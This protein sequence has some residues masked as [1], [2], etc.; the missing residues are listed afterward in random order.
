[1]D[2]LVTRL[3]PFAAM[4]RTSTVGMAALLCLVPVALKAQS[5]T[6]SN[7]TYTGYSGSTTASGATVSNM[8]GTTY[9]V[10]NYTAAQENNL[11]PAQVFT[12]NTPDT[13]AMETGQSYYLTQTG[14]FNP[15]FNTATSG[16][17]SYGAVAT[18]DTI[19]NFLNPTSSTAPPGVTAA[20]YNTP[21]NFTGANGTDVTAPL[22]IQ[23]L[24][25]LTVTQADTTVSFKINHDEAFTLAIGNQTVAASGYATTSP[26]N[27][28]FENAGTYAFTLELVNTDG[29]GILDTTFTAETGTVSIATTSGGGSDLLMPA[30][31]PEPSTTAAML[32]ALGALGWLGGRKRLPAA[33]RVTAD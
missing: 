6:I 23:L 33:V 29:I 4:K 10:T 21:F 12:N 16:E 27:L 3:L 7:F 11:T 5:M 8:T 18:G 32:L 9:T 17:I 28:T 15:I 19:Q 13:T 22:V 1:M 2:S 31:V 24:G 25:T 30:A 14:T 20:I 26:F